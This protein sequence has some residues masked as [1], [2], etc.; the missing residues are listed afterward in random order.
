MTWL[1][2]SFAIFMFFSWKI[3]GGL[4][5]KA[6]WDRLIRAQRKE[7]SGGAL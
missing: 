5:L 3:G 4:V 2:F 6:H 1:I 7:H